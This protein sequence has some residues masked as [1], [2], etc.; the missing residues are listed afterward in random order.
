M[1]AWLAASA[2]VV[3]ADLHWEGHARTMYESYRNPELGLGGLERDAWLQQRFQVLGSWREEASTSLVAEWTWGKTWGKSAPLAPP[4]QDDLDLLQGFLRTE[5]EDFEWKLGRQSLVYGSGRLL[6]QREGANQ[7]LSHDAVR[8]SWRGDEGWQVDAWVASAVKI[9]PGSFDNRSE[10]ENQRW[11]GVYG[12]RTL[13]EGRGLD[14]YYLGLREGRS[15][16]VPEG[17]RETRHTLGVRG[18]KVDGEWGLDAEGMFQWGRAG[19]REIIAGAVSFDG[20]YAISGW[21]WEPTWHLRLDAISGGQSG[22]VIHTFHPLFAA[23]NYF[24]EGGFL[25]PSNLWNLNPRVEMKPT[26]DLM[27]SIGV[28]F[29]WRFDAEDAVYAP[30]FQ[31]VAGAASSRDLGV[32]WNLLLEWRSAPSTTW[33]LGYTHHEAGSSLKAVA[34]MDADYL[35]LSFRLGF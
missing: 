17:G 34:G 28:N 33:S 2:W 31:P 32:A 30:P 16:V 29:Q 5:V 35:Q 6:A 21:R 1:I 23:N 19:D 24:N 20:R 13:G 4:D 27:L 11:W 25:S 7:R 14:V 3:G 15:V 18:W 22:E 26:E 9:R 8:I 10:P 12:M